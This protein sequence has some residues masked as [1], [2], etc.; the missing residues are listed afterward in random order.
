MWKSNISDVCHRWNSYPW[1]IRS[2]I[3]HYKTSYIRAVRFIL[4]YSLLFILTITLS[5][6]CS[7]PLT[8]LHNSFLDSSN[9]F[10]MLQMKILFQTNFYVSWRTYQVL[11]VYLW[12]DCFKFRSDQVNAML[13]WLLLYAF[14]TRAL[15]SWKRNAQLHCTWN[16]CCPCWLYFDLFSDFENT[17]H[18]ILGTE[19]LVR[20]RYRIHVIFGYSVSILNSIIKM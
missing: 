14:D 5:W 7:G 11:V 18:H 19:F 8:E 4:S 6:L 1:G 9:D 15:A 2:F 17:Q 20:V 13:V 12:F 3:F 16:T 10:I